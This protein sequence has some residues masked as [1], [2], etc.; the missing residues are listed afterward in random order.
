MGTRACVYYLLFSSCWLTAAGLQTASG[1][2]AQSPAMHGRAFPA[3]R[4]YDGIQ[5]ALDAF[6]L[7]EEKRQAAVATQLGWNQF[8]RGQVANF[9]PGDSTTPY[10]DY[11]WPPSATQHSREFTYAY[12][13]REAVHWY[14]RGW[15]RRQSVFEPWPIVPGDIYGVIVQ[16]PLRQPV[17]QW[18]GQTGPNRWESHPVYDPPLPAFRPLPEVDSPLLDETPFAVP[19]STGGERSIRPR[20]R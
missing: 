6:R 20:E 16:P 15:V 10:G 17:A 12:G 14:G 19:R 7:A 1:Q 5:A 4:P 9:P 3:D 18:Q 2:T 13:A 11:G 8:Y